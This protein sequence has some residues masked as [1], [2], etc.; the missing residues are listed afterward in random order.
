M[1]IMFCIFRDMRL[2]SI[3]GGADEVSITIKSFPNVFPQF[4]PLMTIAFIITGILLHLLNVS[5]DVA[6]HLQ[7]DGNS[8]EARE[9]VA[10]GLHR[11]FHTDENIFI[12]SI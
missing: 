9:K 11:G 12:Y 6:D 1:L 10:Q 4:F 8:S 2:T 7:A 3:G 5:G